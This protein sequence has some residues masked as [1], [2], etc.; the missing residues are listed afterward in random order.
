MGKRSDGDF[1]RRKNDL[2][3]TWDPRAVPALL[4]HLPPVVRFVEPCAGSGVLLDQLEAAGHVCVD[5]YDIEPGRSDIY[6]ADA[7]DYTTPLT[8][9]Y[10]ITNPPWTREILR[11]LI[12][13]LSDQAPTWLLFD[14]DWMHTKQARPFRSRLRKIVSIG[15]LKWIEG[16]KH[17]GK[18]NCAWYLFD[19]PA[20]EIAEFHLRADDAHWD[21]G[22]GRAMAPF[23]RP[24][25]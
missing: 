14:A 4:P 8:F 15:R 5:S 21:L 12:A 1:E 19:R 16:S 24:A 2:Y 13:H 17:D 6:K 10:F 3:E 25:A 23:E 9:D 11:P 20:G 22:T 18:D 7:N